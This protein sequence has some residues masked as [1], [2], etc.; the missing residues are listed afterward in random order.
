MQTEV[1]SYNS[2]TTAV[3]RAI[4][5]AVKFIAT[6]SCKMGCLPRLGKPAFEL[7]SNVQARNGHCIFTLA[8]AEYLQT[9][10]DYGRVVDFQ[11][12]AKK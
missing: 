4:A 3:L 12:L 7:L 8:I 6:A 2:L 1:L 5:E 9:A 10:R 11:W